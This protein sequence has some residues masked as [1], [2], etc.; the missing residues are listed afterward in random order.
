M[1]N[2]ATGT[3]AAEHREGGF[4]VVAHIWNPEGGEPDRATAYGYFFDRDGA[5][6]EACSWSMDGKSH[7]GRSRNLVIVEGRAE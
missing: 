7:S 1:Q 2:L 4:G 6:P 5:R 3:Y